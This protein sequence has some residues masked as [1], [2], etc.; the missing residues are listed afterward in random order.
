MPQPTSSTEEGAARAIRAARCSATRIRVACS[1]PSGV[2]YIRAARSPNLASARCRSWT[3]VSAAATCSGVAPEPA[4][5]APSRR[6]TVALRS[7]SPACSA[8]T[9]WAWVSSVW[10]AGES[11]HRNASR[12]MP[13]SLALDL[14]E[15]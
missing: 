12:S 15:C 11:S 5:A 7:G 6:S 13:K 14:T 8:Y 1:S 3:W 9:W 2:K 4:W 10:P